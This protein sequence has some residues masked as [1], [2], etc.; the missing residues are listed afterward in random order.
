M[1]H[2]VEHHRSP[3]LGSLRLRRRDDMRVKEEVKEEPEDIKPPVIPAGYEVPPALHDEARD[4]DILGLSFALVASVTEIERDSPGFL[5]TVERSA[6]MAA[7]ASTSVDA[8]GA[9]TYQA[10]HVGAS[11]SRADSSSTLILLNDDIFDWSTAFD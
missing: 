1:I 7:S 3:P 11:T 6:Q 10:H 4:D 2:D 5:E 9:S 8:A